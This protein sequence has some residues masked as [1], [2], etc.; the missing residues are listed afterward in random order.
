[1]ATLIYSMNMKSLILLA[2]LVGGLFLS[3][4]G[5]VARDPYQHFFEESFG[6]LQ[7]DLKSAREEGK[8][9]L[10]I[11]FEMDECPFCHRMETTV[12]NQPPVQEYFRKHFRILSMDIEGD[13]PITDFKG[14]ATTQKDFSFKQNQVRATPVFIFYD[15]KGNPIT[16]YTGPTRGVEDFMWL[17]EYVVSGAYQDM[18]FTRYKREQQKPRG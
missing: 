18:S 2:A 5:A 3:Q 16:R 9:G 15:L 1:M 4:A 10:L 8:Q 13:V 17:G 12:L 7:E 11:F 14:Q 6:D